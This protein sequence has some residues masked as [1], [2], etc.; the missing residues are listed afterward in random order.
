MVGGQRRR[1][2][3]Q[4][5]R[6]FYAHNAA[7]SKAVSNDT[8]DAPQ[9]TREA[10]Q[11]KH[12]SFEA[13]SSGRLNVS[14]TYY[15]VPR[16]PGKRRRGESEHALEIIELDFATLDDLSDNLQNDTPEFVEFTKQ[17]RTIV[18]GEALRIWQS[19]ADLFLEEF[20]RLEGRGDYSQNICVC[21]EEDAIY[22]CQDCHGSELF[23]HLCTIRV[24]E[25]QP[26]HTLEVCA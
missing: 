13:G 17:K 20:L 4:Y 19:D 18:Q 2:L 22:R 10:R 9:H 15:T 8:N 16:S 3:K 26:L 23:C 24:H 5:Q 12:S 21:G 1:A 25:R 7:A 6:N 14:S 11:R